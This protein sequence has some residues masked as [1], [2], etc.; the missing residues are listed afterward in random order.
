MNPSDGI[1]ERFN[2]DITKSSLFILDVFWR[3]EAISRGSKTND[4]S[5][6]QEIS[7]YLEVSDR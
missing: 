1:F 5:L 3:N 4:T 2:I 7:Y 6:Y